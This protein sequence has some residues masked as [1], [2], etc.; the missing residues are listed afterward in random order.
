MSGIAQVK[1][2]RLFRMWIDRMCL[3][4]YNAIRR[5]HFDSKCE[6]AV[7]LALA[8]AGNDASETWIAIRSREE[9]KFDLE[10]ATAYK[11]RAIG[12]AIQKLEADGWINVRR[13]RGKGN[14]YFINSPATRAL[15]R[16]E[17]N[18]IAAPR[19][20]SDALNPSNI[21]K[22]KNDGELGNAVD[23]CA[24]SAMLLPAGVSAKQWSAYTEVRAQKGAPNTDYVL[25]EL[26]SKLH[27]LDSRGGDASGP[28][29]HNIV[30]R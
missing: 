12:M 7:L 24:D 17:Q 28:R 23:K 22:K 4:L 19:S 25:D 13:T 3:K 1:V 10:T 6:K 8:D 30:R 2:P 16:T 27:Y 26:L 5:I 15:L 20:A 18:A 9:H 21:Q 11:K 29:D 14:R